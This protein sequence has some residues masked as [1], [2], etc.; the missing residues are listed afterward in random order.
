MKIKS[1]HNIFIL[2]LT[3]FCLTALT[4]CGGL[5]NSL[6]ENDKETREEE[7][8]VGEAVPDGPAPVESQEA[9]THPTEEDDVLG[10]GIAITKWDLW[11]SGETLLRG[12]NIWQALVVP[13]L[14]GLE[15][16]GDGHV[17]PPFS[18]ADFDHLASLGAN[19]VTIS[20]PGL[21]TEKPPFEVDE[22]AVEYV[23]SLVEMIGKADMFATI[24]FRTGSGRSEYSLCCDG[25]HWAW[26]YFN[27]SMWEEEDAQDA[28]ASM[29][30]YTAEHYRDNPYVVGYKL[31][32]EPNASG[33]LFDIW[34]PEPFYR[35]YADT[36]YDWNQLYPRIVTA[37]REVDSDT[38]ILVNADGF[39][40]IEWLPYLVPVDQERI[41]YIAHQYHPYEQYTNQEPGL[42]NEYPG[43]Y[44]IDYDG[45]RDEF[46]RDWL[47]E[48][49][50][51]LDEYSAGHGVAVGVDEFGVARYAPNA[52]DYMG[53]IM[54]LFEQR[55]INYSLWEWSTSWEPF[56]EEV[57]H[58]NFRFGPDADSQGDTP[59]DLQDVITS[60]W[61]LNTLRP[62]NV[63]W[64][65]D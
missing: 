14:D 4:N 19:Y 5:E 59:N 53:D 40:A 36:L 12:A 63:T 15:F 57:N 38:P 49:L 13:E 65:E 39:S 62:S 22:A 64:V 45:V 18:Q 54:G 47:D 20:G 2:C 1:T 51:T 26:G 6:Y 41:V 32:V 50:S 11:S 25:E 44:D 30:R 27:D 8:E 43:S 37:I 3:I 7:S 42:G 24:G 56:V 33:I 31:M 55:G 60:Y 61:E 17:G 21:F 52:A 58:F 23:D 34:E 48:L 46:N 28:W 9:E 10:N 29:W 16:K 35:R